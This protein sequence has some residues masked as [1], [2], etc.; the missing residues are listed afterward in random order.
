MK[1]DGWKYIWYQIMMPIEKLYFQFPIVWI[2]IYDTKI[3]FP[4]KWIGL[5]HRRLEHQTYTYSENVQWDGI[6]D[7]ID[8]INKR[9]KLSK[10]EEYLL[11]KIQNLQVE[12][13]H[14]ETE[15]IKTSSNKIP[16]RTEN[17]IKHSSL[18]DLRKKWYRV[19]EYEC[20]PP[21]KRA[22]FVN[23]ILQDN[24]VVDLTK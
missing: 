17:I 23:G 2:G 16:R 19:H 3:Q 15:Y 21:I 12:N 22:F 13:I 9:E 5:F 7:D 10:L 14:D 4:L 1:K 18:D 6:D 20:T 8:R 24:E 11:S